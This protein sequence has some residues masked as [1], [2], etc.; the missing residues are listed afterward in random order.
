M[1]N[2]I[3]IY[4][5][6]NRF[7]SLLKSPSGIEAKFSENG[8]FVVRNHKDEKWLIEFYEK[9]NKNGFQIMNEF[10]DFAEEFEDEI[11]EVENIKAALSYAEIKEARD[12]PI[13]W[14]KSVIQ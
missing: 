10:S 9:V 11:L 3:F 5:L 14:I 12:D 13:A 8:Q 7:Q 4:V 2:L 1:K 6:I